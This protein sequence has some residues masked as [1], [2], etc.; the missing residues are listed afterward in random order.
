MDIVYVLGKGSVWNDNEIRFS[1]RSLAK[2][3]R[4]IGKVFI[5]GERPNFLKNVI[6]IPCEDSCSVA[7]QNTYKKTLLACKDPRL[8]ENFLHMNDDFFVIE[9]IKAAEFPFYYNKN[10]LPQYNLNH[11]YIAMIEKKQAE[12]LDV[13]RKSIFNFDLHRPIRFNKNLFMNMPVLQPNSLKFKPRSFYCNYY[14]VPRIGSSDPIVFL[15]RS[16][17][18]YNEAVAG[19]TD[20]SILSDVARDPIF[21]KWIEKRF[22]EPSYF[23]K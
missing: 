5:V 16:I 6:H 21:Q 7:W 10:R 18:K 12:N 4:D 9:P 14:G 1:L 15:Y 11:R 19:L 17:K 23:E 2:N 13:P 8:S 3:V 22:P 20:F